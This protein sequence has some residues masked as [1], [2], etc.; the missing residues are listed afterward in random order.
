[1][2]PDHYLTPRTKINL[3]WI[4]DLKVRSETIKEIEENIGTKLLDISL[5]DVSV[6]LTAKA[7]RTKG[8]IYKLDYTK[9]K[10]LCKAKKKPS[11]K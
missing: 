1:M 8:K 6:N 3:K 9:L 5:R 4:I 2:K 11:T 7:R 10:I